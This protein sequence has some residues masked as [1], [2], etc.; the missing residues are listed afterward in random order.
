MKSR[1]RERERE[2]REELANNQ[3]G[4]AEQRAPDRAHFLSEV[5]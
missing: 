1:E 5:C 3:A 2:S 4:I